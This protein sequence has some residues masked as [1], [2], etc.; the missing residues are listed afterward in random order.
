MVLAL[1]VFLVPPLVFGGAWEPWFY[2][3]VLLVIACPCALVISTPVTIVAALAGA[4]KQGV[5]IKGGVHLETPAKLKAIA[6]DK[7][8]TLTEGRPKVVEL[9][10]LGNR[11]EAQLLELAAALEVRSEHPLA[12]AVLDEARKHGVN[13]VPADSVRRCAAGRDRPD[14]RLR[15]MAWIPELFGG[16]CKDGGGARRPAF[17]RSDC[18]CRT[19]RRRCG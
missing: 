18:R 13:V 6:M 8:G 4:A 3:A 17:G 14:R 5:L 16:A 15:G 12:R 9:V 11:T 2:R 10:P 7:T 1:A 19:H